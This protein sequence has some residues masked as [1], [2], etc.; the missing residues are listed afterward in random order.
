MVTCLRNTGRVNL[1]VARISEESA[2][3]GSLPGRCNAATHGVGRQVENVNVTAGRKDNSIPPV[4]LDLTGDQI[5][6]RDPFGYAINHNQV[7]HFAASKQFN[8]ADL[9]LTHQCR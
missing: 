3:L 4:R 9:D 8:C 5:T 7:E 6:N 2:F 1:G